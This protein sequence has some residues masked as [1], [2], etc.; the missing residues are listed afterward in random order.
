MK[1]TLLSA[2]FA[3]AAGM[4]F[5]AETNLYVNPE[6]KTK[7]DKKGNLAIVE[8]SAW[9]K[10]SI[11]GK[12]EGSPVL[13]LEQTKS[14]TG[15]ICSV[16]NWHNTKRD[17][18]PGK[19]TFSIWCNPQG[20]TSHITLYYRC[21]PAGQKERIRQKSNICNGGKVP[22][23]K[24]TQLVLNFEVKPGETKHSFGF[25]V[26]SAGN[27]GPNPK[28]VLFAKPLVVPQNEE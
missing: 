24:W 16:E 1:T 9:G 5:A 3:L 13:R 10:A 11:D 15:V 22:P 6:F 23:G 21:L 12:Y 25:A 18:K 14:E 4:L 17:L 20:K 8:H 7:K 28:V 26:Y 19:Y 27:L 2:A